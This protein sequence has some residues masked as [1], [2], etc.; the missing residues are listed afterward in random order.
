MHFFARGI[1]IAGLISSFAVFAQTPQDVDTHPEWQ[2]HTGKPSG[3]NLV[4]V[5]LYRDKSTAGFFSAGEWRTQLGTA[6]TQCSE[7]LIADLDER[8][9]YFDFDKNAPRYSPGA[10]LQGKAGAY[11]GVRYDAT[12][13][14]P[15][16]SDFFTVPGPAMES[17]RDLST[18]FKQIVH[19]EA[20]SIVALENLIVQRTQERAVQEHAAYVKDFD[21]VKTLDDVTAFEK[22]YGSNDPD[23]LIYR[24]APLKKT[25]LH[26][27]YQEQFAS[28]HTSADW[29]S[30]IFNYENN[31]LD[32]LIQD[33]KVRLAA[34]VKVEQAEQ[35]QRERQLAQEQKQKKFNELV[36][37]ISYCNHQIDAAFRAIKREQDI[38]QVSGY[39]NKIIMRQAGEIIVGCRSANARDYETYRKMGG[40]KHLNKLN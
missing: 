24:F 28:S 36:S 29:K 12:I 15:C 30:F 6:I 14:S 25:L 39:E 34:S 2:I 16:T 27:R 35:Q 20:R 5:C 18:E 7:R 3:K 40:T 1:A 10:H 19:Y 38:S 22:R 8:G 9:L 13:Y 11:C 17:Y 37:L 31:D 33:A 32:H 4:Q 23:H 21:T 26:E